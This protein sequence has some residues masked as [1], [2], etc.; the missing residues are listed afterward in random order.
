M[1]KP[2]KYS[3]MYLPVDEPSAALVSGGGWLLDQS[4]ATPEES[5]RA[6]KETVALVDRS[7]DGKI[8]V[9]GVEAAA[10][11]EME[12]L[13]V[14]AG[15]EQ[16]YGQAVRLRPDLFFIRARPDGEVAL[17]SDLVKKAGSATGLVTI[18]DMTHG[19]SGLRLIGPHCRKLLGRLCGLD[20]RPTHFVQLAAKQSSVAKTSQIIIRHDLEGQTSF[21]LYGP[22]SLGAYLR[23]TLLSA[24]G[25]LGIVATVSPAELLPA[26]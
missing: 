5:A 20:F 21:L 2:M 9:E 14:Q 7:S 1:K 26:V 10:L 25:D 24:G 15:C 19:L 18:T 8:R 12:Q 23:S 3:P 4:D 13:S 16:S 11:L 17:L 22:R 6:A